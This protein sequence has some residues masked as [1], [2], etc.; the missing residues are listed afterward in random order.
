MALVWEAGSVLLLV[1]VS[2]VLGWAG[3]TAFIAWV[4]RVLRGDVQQLGAARAAALLV[5][6][7]TALAALHGVQVLWWAS[8][9]RWFVLSSLE[10]AI[11]FS[12]ATYSTV[13]YGDVVLPLEWRLVGPLESLAGV[14]WCG[15]SVSLLFATATRLLAEMESRGGGR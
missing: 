6:A 3:M 11:Y 15:V 8:W 10:T 5:Q 1:T 4:E 13:G 12:A 2:L 7:T 9:Y 14:L